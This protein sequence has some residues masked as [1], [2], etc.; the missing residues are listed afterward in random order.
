[1]ELAIQENYNIPMHFTKK[2][3]RVKHEISERNDA[4]I[5]VG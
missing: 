3:M 5:P 1:M 2:I 4:T